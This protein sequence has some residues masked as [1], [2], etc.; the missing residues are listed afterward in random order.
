MWAVLYGAVIEGWQKHD[1]I[2]QG[3]WV[4]TVPE[5]GRYPSYHF[6]ALS[7]PFVPWDEVAKQYIES[8]NAA[9]KMK[10][11]M[12]LMLGL[13]YVPKT[14]APEHVQLMNRREDYPRGRVPERAS[15]ITIAA[16]VQMRGIYYEVVCWAS[17]RESWTIEADY[18]DGANDAVDEGAF[19]LLSDLYFKTWP[20]AF[21]K[22]RR[23][24]EFA[25]DSAWR[26]S[27]VYEFCRRHPGMK[28]V[29]GLDGWNIPALGVATD[30]DINYA[31]G[32]K[33]KGG[34]K[35]RGVG[36]W[37]LKETIY[38]NLSLTPTTDGGKII[39]ERLL[40]LRRV[41]G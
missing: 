30:Q 35:L 4:A 41:V 15:L 39:P 34:V 16:D 3:R 1:L 36:T 7:S 17:N 6:D 9:E 21:G 19:K 37:Q 31:T 38:N 27:I 10:P 14:D 23:P 8:G 28:A 2:K 26:T 13:P 25:C 29:K 18:L 22:D 11:F 12:N 33:L 24:D 40:P 5:P 32:R 20:D